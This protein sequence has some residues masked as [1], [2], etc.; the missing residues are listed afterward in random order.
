MQIKPYNNSLYSMKPKPAE[1]PAAPEKRKQAALHDAHKYQK[2]DFKK[3]GSK[4]FELDDGAVVVSLSGDEQPALE[5]E[6]PEV[7]VREEIDGNAMYTGSEEKVAAKSSSKLTDNSSQLIRRLVAAISQFEVRQVVSEA[8]KNLV[9]LYMAAATG[10]ADTAKAA[11]AIIR[12]LEKTIKRGYRKMADLGK[13]ENMKLKQI[14]AEQKKERQRAKEIGKELREHIRKR[15]IREK[16]Y[17]NERDDENK[18]GEKYMNGTLDAATE[19]QIAIQAQMQAAMEAASVQS[20]GGVGE[21]AADI[22]GAPS[23]E[24]SGAPSGEPSGGAGDVAGGGIEAAI[25]VES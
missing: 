19:A 7:A 13:E 3:P 8:S 22:S 17:L 5:K 2:N 21:V 1:K 16:R 6:Q 25:S 12:K 24:S 23:G 11:R 10:D 9:E 14:R 20:A 18:N 15:K 4:T